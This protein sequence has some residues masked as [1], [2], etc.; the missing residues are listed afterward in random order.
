MKNNKKKSQRLSAVF[1]YLFLCDHINSVKQMRREGLAYWQYMWAKGLPVHIQCQFCLHYNDYH[2]F[3]SSL[4]TIYT[5][6]TDLN[7]VACSKNK[8]I[9]MSPPL[10][11]YS[12]LS[13]TIDS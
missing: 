11:S 12:S 1:L 3:C 2:C 4:C 10:Y 13:T 7:K 6:Y 8:N 5:I 9:I